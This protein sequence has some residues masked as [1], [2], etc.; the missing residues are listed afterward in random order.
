MLGLIGGVVGAGLAYAGVRFLVVIGPSNLPRIREISIDARTL[1]FTFVLS[2][3][4]GLLFGL[5]PAL[6]YARPHAGSALQSVGR[7]ISASR[8]RH[9]ARNLL[10]V[11]QM[12]MA[13]VLLVSAGLMMRTFAALLRVDP[14]FSDLQHLQVMRISMPDSLIAEP[15]RVTQAQNAILDKLVRRW[16]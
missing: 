13:L 15:E 6:K 12:T 2:V 1:G 14:G 5:I 16:R 8:E 9:R 3:P 4:S 10:V 11:G 7:T